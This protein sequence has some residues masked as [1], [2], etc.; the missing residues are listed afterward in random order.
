MTKLTTTAV[1][2]CCLIA[3]QTKAQW[4][5][6]TISTNTSSDVNIK[7]TLNQGNLT[8]FRDATEISNLGGTSYTYPKPALSIL[9]YSPSISAAWPNNASATNAPQSDFEIMG[10]TYSYGGSSS[11]GS[12]LGYN[13]PLF[14]IGGDCQL[15]VGG[16]RV[17]NYANAIYGPSY[18]NSPSWFKSS[19]N[20]GNLKPNGVYN[21]YKLSVD[22]D[23]ICKKAIVQTSSW[24]DYVFKADYDL[25]PLNKVEEFIKINKHLPNIPSE[26][27]V[28][29]KGQDVAKIQK[30]QQAKIEELT[31]YLIELKKEIEL[32]KTKN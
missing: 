4:T 19:V 26:K 8:I 28:L 17:S 30:L 11:S 9:R 23:I 2:I 7:T 21:G 18:F 12:F 29:E 16:P 6:S 27:D 13:T 5:G 24:A 10:A 14:T 3:M 22:G 1:M 25:M 15:K 20:I 31:L 32:L